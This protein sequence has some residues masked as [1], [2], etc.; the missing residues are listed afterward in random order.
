MKER[1]WNELAKEL[2]NLAYF[3]YKPAQ[4][5]VVVCYDEKGKPDGLKV[6]PKQG[7]TIHVAEQIVDFC[8][9]KQLNNYITCEEIGNELIANVMIF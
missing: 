4:V 3:N 8:R 9:C 5:N 1:N 7:R 6:Y 2:E